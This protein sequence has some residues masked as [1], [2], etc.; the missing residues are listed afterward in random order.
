MVRGDG[1]ELADAGI[2]AFAAVFLHRRVDDGLF[3]LQHGEDVG[4]EDDGAAGV[5]AEAQDR[6][7]GIVER[8]PR[9]GELQACR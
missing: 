3:V 1:V 9:L 2:E 7:H 4:A 6:L 5:V 8:G